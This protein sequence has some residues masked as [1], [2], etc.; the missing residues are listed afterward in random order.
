[1]KSSLYFHSTALLGSLVL[2]GTMQAMD[3]IFTVQNE[4]CSNGNGW[5]YASVSGGVPPYTYDWSGLGTND[6]LFNLAAGSYSLTVTDLNSDQYTEVVQL[7]DLPDL[8]LGGVINQ[9]LLYA[10]PGQCNGAFSVHAYALGGTAPYNFQPGQG[11]Y[12]GPDPNGNPMFGPYCGGEVFTLDVYDAYGCPGSTTIEIHAPVPNSVQ[13]IDIAPSCQGGAN[14][15]VTLTAANDNWF[16]S[17][18]LL[19]NAALATVDQYPWVPQNITFSGLLPGHYVLERDWFIINPECMDTIGFDIPDAGTTCGSIV[20]TVFL[21]HDQDC[22]QGPD[23][24]GVPYALLLIEPGGQLAITNSDGTYARSLPFGAFTITE[25]SAALYPVC[26]VARPVPFTVSN[27]SPMATIDLADSSL[28]PLDLEVFWANVAPPRPGFTTTYHAAVRNLSGQLSGPVNVSFTFDPAQSFVSASPTPTNV[29][30]NSIMWD[31]PAFGSFESVPFHVALSLPPDP[32][33]IGTTLS[34]TFICGN[35]LTEVTLANNSHVFAPVVVGSFDPNDKVVE[36]GDVFVIGVDSVLYYTIRF[37]NTGTASAIDVVVSDTLP[38]TLDLSSF[39]QGAAS[40]PFT[41]AFKP[42]RVV[43]WKFENILLP[44]S[45]TNEPESHGLVS[46]RIRPVQP[47]LPGTAFTNIA[48]IYFDFNPPVIT[49]PSVLVA[50]FS[51]GVPDAFNGGDVDV[52]PNP[53]NG[54]V[55]VRSLTGDMRSLAL[56]AMDGRTVLAERLSG[57]SM[58]QIDVA[59]IA[60]GTYVVVITTGIGEQLRTRLIKL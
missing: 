56:L 15:S 32:L 59:A 41:L 42:G 51:T 37:Q 34:N 45:G 43:E 35:T 7:L 29:V 6:T 17:N 23:D 19:L 8:D 25:A 60:S 4:T 12:L 11:G 55:T 26:P 14:G 21:D 3:I 39:Q 13:V 48:N 52:F 54:S 9:Q 22:V 57:V 53:T 24:P 20:G 18:I 47:L 46:F 16:T 2:A 49:E 58:A 1:M 33:L 30:G 40:H 50:E 10:C 5:I 44:D 28:V 31:L 38:G 36:P 27:G